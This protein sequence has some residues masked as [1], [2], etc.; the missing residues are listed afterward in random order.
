MATGADSNGSGMAV[1]LELLAIFSQ[2]YA[3]SQRA[4]YNLVFALTAGGQF[5]YQGSRS[6]IDDFNERYSGII[7][8][9]YE[10]WE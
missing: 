5:N 3:Q 2:L 6:F 7:R 4:H 9:E 1:L 8:Y 10:D